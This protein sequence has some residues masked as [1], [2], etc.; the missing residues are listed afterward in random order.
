MRRR[1]G[2]LHSEDYE[3]YLQV[4][5][6]DIQLCAT[7][8]SKLG[9]FYDESPKKRGLSRRTKTYPEPKL[10]PNSLFDDFEFDRSNECFTEQRKLADSTITTFNVM[11]VV[12]P[13]AA[14]SEGCGRH[15][16]ELLADLSQELLDSHRSRLENSVD[17]LIRNITR[18]DGSE[19]VLKVWVC[20]QPTLPI[21]ESTP[22]AD[23]VYYKSIA[24]YFLVGVFPSNEFS[25]L[26]RLV[27]FARS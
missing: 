26:T 6:R 5:T 7:S 21:F 1:S 13:S 9:V 14:V 2:A 25:E 16:H 22:L 3:G 10:V 4:P 12:P 15:S 17:L 11:V 23:S 19:L 20:Y 18:E 8:D 24:T 27:A